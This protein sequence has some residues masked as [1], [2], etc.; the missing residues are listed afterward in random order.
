MTAL[1]QPARRSVSPPKEKAPAKSVD[2]RFHIFGPDA[3]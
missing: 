3:R 1:C 2:C